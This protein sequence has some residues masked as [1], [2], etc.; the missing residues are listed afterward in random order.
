MSPGSAFLLF[1]INN[2]GSLQ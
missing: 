1:H 2:D